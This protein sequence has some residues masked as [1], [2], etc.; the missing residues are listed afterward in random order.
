M[1]QG[2]WDMVEILR[3]KGAVKVSFFPDGSLSSVEFTELPP[4]TEGPSDEEAAVP[5]KRERRVAGGLVPREKPN[6]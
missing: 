1:Q 2:I 5:V 3:A 4:Q 6:E